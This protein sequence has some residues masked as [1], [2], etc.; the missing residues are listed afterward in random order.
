MPSITASKIARFEVTSGSKLH[1]TQAAHAAQ[2]WLHQRM[3][4]LQYQGE[5]HV[6]FFTILAVARRV[7]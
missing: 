4:Y 2:H 5:K 3:F 7:I 1:Q 6:V